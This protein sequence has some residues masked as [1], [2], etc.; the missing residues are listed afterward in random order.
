M[1]LKEIIRTLKQKRE[2]LGLT[3]DDVSRQTRM[4]GT[5]IANIE[6][7]DIDKMNAVYLKGFLKI[8]IEFLGLQ[9]DLIAALDNEFKKKVVSV[10]AA[11]PESLS[12]PRTSSAVPSQLRTALSVLIRYRK[13]IGVLIVAAF[14]GWFFLHGIRAL[15][16]RISTPKTK[17]VSSV[18]MPA[19]GA[20]QKTAVYS[21]FKMKKASEIRVVLRA[22]KECFIRVKKDG[23]IVFDGIV[24]KGTVRTWVG[25]KEIAMSI[26]DSSAVE[27]EVNGELLP[28]GKRK[29]SIKSLTVGLERITIQ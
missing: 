29:R 8:Y 6:N 2:A 26:N 13:T 14:A 1:P 19:K 25:Q 16:K 22:R 17:T 27:I 18:R 5:V 9:K 4:N 23:M 15:S 11:K 10:A 3:I 24:P 20:V 12:V 7:N 28:L 21:G